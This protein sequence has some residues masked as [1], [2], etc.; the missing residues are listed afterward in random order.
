MNRLNSESSNKVVGKTVIVGVT[1]GIAAYKAAELVSS[2]VKKGLNVHVILTKAALDFITPLTLETLAKNPVLVD[3]PT[4]SQGIYVPHIDLALK[5]ELFVVVPATA[6]TIA[7]IATGIADNLLTSTI[8]A[9]KAPVLLAPSMN[10]NMYENPITQK[11]I[12]FLK[13]IG[14]HFIEP[15]EGFLAC[16]TVGK[17]RL[18]AIPVILEEIERLLCLKKDFQGKRVIVTA[19]GTREAIDPVRYIGNRSSGKMGFAIAKE[20]YKRGAQVTLIAGNTTVEPP[21]G[22]KLIR[23]FST[24]K[25]RDEVLKVFPDADVVIKA[26]AVA[27]YKPKTVEQSKIKKGEQNLT[28]ELCPTVDILKELG[29]IKDKQILVGFAAETDQV[30][31]NAKKKLEEKNLDLLVANDVS[32]EGAG[33]EVDTNIVSILYLNGQVEE[34]PLLTKAE[35]ATLVLDRIAALPRFECQVKES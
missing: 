12:E 28:I 4:G 5:A 34:F 17:G 7:K 33:F 16:G 6:N 30:A 29:K 14:F 24:E 18:P 31:M 15:E 10:V 3:E 26:A 13:S 25:M 21:Q 20:A 32:K 27:D 9:T 22:V 19:G 1:G 23:A 35:I 2:L 11:N 8:L